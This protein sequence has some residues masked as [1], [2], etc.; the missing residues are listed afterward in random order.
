MGL[1]GWAHD[2]KDANPNSRA[3][4]H[5]TETLVAAWWH[6]GD[7][8]YLDRAQKVIAMTRDKYAAGWP[9]PD[10]W[11]GLVMEAMAKYH[12]ASNDKIALDTLTAFSDHL[13]E[14]GYKFPNTA[15]GYAYLWKATGKEAYLQAAL[16]NINVGRID[17]LGKDVP[18]HFRS[19][20]YLTGLLAQ[21][22]QLAPR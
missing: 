21:T 11:N 20:P 15:Y 1:A 22:G 9:K 18:M 19:M 6:T 2:A 14:A 10:F 5:Q 3:V 16:A 17:H 13:I 4:A 8:K 7:K 12:A